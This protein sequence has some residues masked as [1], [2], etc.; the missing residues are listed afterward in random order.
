MLQFRQFDL[1]IP[2]S[3]GFYSCV[4]TKQMNR[5]KYYFTTYCI[6]SNTYSYFY[7]FIIT[8]YQTYPKCTQVLQGLSRKQ[9][10]TSNPKIYLISRNPNMIFIREKLE[11]GD[12]SSIESISYV[13][14]MKPTCVSHPEHKKI[15][16]HQN[17]SFP[18]M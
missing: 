4:V 5:N 8:V 10:M 3:L 6:P 7:V 9:A 11:K 16:Y 1:N 12:P 18:S 14:H 15:F 2:L 17:A 13:R